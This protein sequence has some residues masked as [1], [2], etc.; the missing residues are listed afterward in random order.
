M[1]THR[2]QLESQLLWLAA[3]DALCLFVAMIAAI[4]LRLGVDALGEYFLDKASGWAYFAAGILSANYLTGSYGLEFRL[5]RFNVAVNWAFSVSLALL[6]VGATS[7][8]WLGGLLGRGVLALAV[9]IYSVLW[10]S[11]RALI[12]HYLFRTRAFSYRVLVLGGGPRGGE[13]LGMVQNTHLRPAHR[14]VAVLE[15]EPPGAAGRSVQ[16]PGWLGG[17]PLL[18]TGA[19]KLNA[20]IE[21]LGV[22][23]VLMAF[24]REE[25]EVRLHPNLRRL[26][27][28]GLAVLTPL[29]AAELY[30]G[31]V[32]LDLVDDRW[33]MQA[34]MGFASPVTMRFK[35]MLDVGLILLTGVPALLLGLL[36]GLLVKASAPRQPVFYAQDRVGRFSRPFRI[37]KFRSMI[38]GAEEG[39]GA[40][41][42]PL[43]DARV[44]RLGRFL[45]RYRLDELPQLWNVLRGDMSLVGPRP[46]RPELA[47]RLEK[48]VP[49]YRERE[50]VLPGLTGWAQIQYPYGATVDDARRKLEYD[51]YYIR[52]LSVGF[53]LRIV[54]RTLR[55]VLF[56]LER[57]ME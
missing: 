55:I 4:V 54:L 15:V 36:V 16:E 43:D 51:L 11:V 5:S 14:V 56:G 2:D 46:E 8:A 30:A 24:E 44:T 17:I 19:D 26:R 34:S 3:L 40:V 22:H 9:G 13:L 21:S 39:T 49:F 50:N 31:K 41:W 20:L 47:D 52:N 27:F 48:D 42:S 1:A 10:L 35:R 57:A 18:R 23:V 45:R 28:G 32:P 33:L 53:D 25:D 38:P 37:Y 7:Y 12:Y 29:A 6:V